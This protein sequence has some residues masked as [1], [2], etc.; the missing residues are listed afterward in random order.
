MAAARMGQP[1]P[2]DRIWYRQD[3]VLHVRCACGHGAHRPVWRWAADGRMDSRRPI[4]ELVA[5]MRCSRCG[6]KASSTQLTEPERQ[7]R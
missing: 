3:W 5:R 2:G 1:C 4:W 7:R 6:G